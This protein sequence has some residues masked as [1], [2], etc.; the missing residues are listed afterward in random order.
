MTNADQIRA[1]TDDEELLSAI[2]TACFRC[3]YNNGEC[4]SGYGEGCIAG[5]LEWLKQDA[6]D[7]DIEGRGGDAE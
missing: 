1:M 3:S 6:T 4:D 5:N 2:G 7:A